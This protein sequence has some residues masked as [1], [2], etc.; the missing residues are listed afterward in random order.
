MFPHMQNWGSL[1]FSGWGFWMGGGWIVICV[2]LVVV[3]WTKQPPHMITYDPLLY[4]NMQHH[5]GYH[6]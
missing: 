4:G 3:E 1:L 2:P 6:L 5:I